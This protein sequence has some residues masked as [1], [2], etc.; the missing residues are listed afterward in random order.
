MPEVHDA[1]T[2]SPQ[3][4]RT[5][6]VVNFDEHGGFF[7]HVVPPAVQDDTV[8]TGTGPFPN[9]KNL[10]FR[11]PAMVVSPFAPKKIEQAGPYE[12]CSVLKMIEWRWNLPSMTVRDAQAKNLAEALDFSSTRAPVTLPAFTPAAVEVCTNTKHLP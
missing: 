10:G 5:V 8:P 6:M 9:L 11:V 3:W 4:G 12:H 2:K 1:I 7:D